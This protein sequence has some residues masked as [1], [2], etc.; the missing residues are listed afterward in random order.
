[1]HVGSTD[2]SSLSKPQGCRTDDERMQEHTHLARLGGSAAIPL[3]LFAQG[4]GT[5]TADTGRIDHTQAPI[6]LSA[7][8]VGHKRLTSW[9]AQRDIRL[10]GKVSSREAALFPGQGHNCRPIPL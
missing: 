3:T 5:T 2:G 1:M 9:T 4:T 7:P 6:G 8:L 10:E